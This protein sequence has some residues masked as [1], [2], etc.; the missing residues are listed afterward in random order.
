MFKKLGDL[1]V[2]TQLLVHTF[3]CRLYRLRKF[4]IFHPVIVLLWNLCKSKLVH[5]AFPPIKLQSRSAD[6]QTATDQYPLESFTGPSHLSINLTAPTPSSDDVDEC[7]NDCISVASCILVREKS[8]LRLNIY[9]A[10]SSDS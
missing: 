7:S 5:P 9:C 2:F 8:L 1:L 6:L 4:T 10:F 3:V